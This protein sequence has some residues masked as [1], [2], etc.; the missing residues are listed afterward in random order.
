MTT[1]TAPTLLIQGTVDELFPLN[2][3]M[4]NAA[5]ILASPYQTPVK[6]LWFCGGHGVCEDPENLGQRDRIFDHTL[7]WMRHYVDGDGQS[8]DAIPAFAWYDQRGVYHS[9]GFLPFQDG[10]AQDQPLRVSADGGLLGIFPVVGG[11]NGL[12]A[13]EAANALDVDITP[14]PGTQLVGAPQLTFTYR[15]IGTS[16]AVYAQFVDDTTGRVVGNIVS[17]VPVV[18]DG[19]E[20]TVS[21][22]LNAIAYTAAEG[23]SLTLQITSSALLFENWSAGVV[24]ISDIRLEVPLRSL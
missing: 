1:M 17:P 24:D 21:V 8:A 4:T 19:V 9:S 14:V 7:A 18:L 10:F 22:P 15:G 20:R 5:A 3:A 11:S 13:G 23:D 12:L 6:M 16:R 2:E